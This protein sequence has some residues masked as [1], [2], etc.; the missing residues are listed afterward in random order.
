MPARAPMNRT[1]HCI[2]VP[3]LTSVS[4]PTTRGAHAGGSAGTLGGRVGRNADDASPVTSRRHDA[5]SPPPR[6]AWNPL[7]IGRLVQSS[8]LSRDSAR[9]DEE[10]R[11]GLVPQEHAVRRAL[12]AHLDDLLSGTTY[13]PNDREGRIERGLV[14]QS[15]TLVNPTLPSGNVMSS[16]ATRTDHSANVTST[17]RVVTA[18]L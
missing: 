14:C 3:E 6:S 1:V 4:D 16:S 17:R 11:N 7:A 9:P 8:M 2:H 18:S 13:T 15:S 10:I 12:S 5:S